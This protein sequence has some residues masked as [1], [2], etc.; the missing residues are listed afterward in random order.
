MTANSYQ[1]MLNGIEEIKPIGSTEVKEPEN[2]NNTNL[3][4]F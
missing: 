3:K 1:I 2:R 4:T